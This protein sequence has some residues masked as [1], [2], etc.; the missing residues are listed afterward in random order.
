VRT[1]HTDPIA[2]VERQE[3]E[4]PPASERGLASALQPAAARWAATPV[5][6][7]DDRK[8]RLKRVDDD[9]RE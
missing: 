2:V 8:A 5:E 1:G 6:D 9:G 4:A 7:F 3:I